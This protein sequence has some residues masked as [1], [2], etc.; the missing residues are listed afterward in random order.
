MH[1]PA[2]LMDELDRELRENCIRV[3]GEATRLAELVE[4]Q[5]R[6]LEASLRRGRA[7]SVVDL[8]DD[9]AAGEERHLAEL[10]NSL[11]GDSS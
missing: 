2:D 8:F 7:A 1:V 6:A 5:R 4:L 10:V 11:R 3:V 9:A